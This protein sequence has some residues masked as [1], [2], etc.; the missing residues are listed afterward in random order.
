ME[1]RHVGFRVHNDLEQHLLSDDGLRFRKN[2][3]LLSGKYDVKPSP[4]CTSSTAKQT[5]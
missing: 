5:G 3:T 4:A 1:Q 2:K